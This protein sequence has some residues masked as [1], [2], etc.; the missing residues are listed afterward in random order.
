[1]RWSPK[2]DL[3]G[4]TCKGGKF[5]AYDPRKEGS[6]VSRDTHKGPK[7][8]KLAWVDDNTF[9]TSGFNTNATREFAIYD[10]RNLTGEPLSAGALGDGIG[11]ANLHF[12]KLHNILYTSGKG[13]S[14]TGV[15]LYANGAL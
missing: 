12:D 4:M 9:I 11:V 5:A 8:Q 10:M 13:E 7:A 6:V 15:Y 3:L 14:T 2:G 1:M